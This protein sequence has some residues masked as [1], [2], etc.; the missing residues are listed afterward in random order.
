MDAVIVGSVTRAQNTLSIDARLIDT[1]TATIICAKDAYSPRID[2]HD[3]SKM[4]NDLAIK[5]KNDLPLVNGYIININKNKFT[6]DIGLKDAVKKGMKCIVYREGESIVHPVTGK[7]IGRMIDELCE[8]QIIEIYDGYSI[9]KITKDKG[10]LVRKLD[11][12]VTK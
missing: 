9:A 4:V 6:L 1:E 3:I 12:V 5:I 2:M 11:K 10:I 7:V 8:I